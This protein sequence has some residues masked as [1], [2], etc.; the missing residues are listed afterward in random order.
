MP[1]E[2]QKLV[3]A[4][5]SEFPLYGIMPWRRSA[6]GNLWKIT[7]SEQTVS[8]FQRPE[9]SGCYAYSIAD[10]NGVRFS[11]QRYRTEDDAIAAL[12][13]ALAALDAALEAG[14]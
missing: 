4:I 8:I 12:F 3:D 10:Q 1:T 6:K 13:I 14:E 7:P 2:S 9:G 11:S 5:R